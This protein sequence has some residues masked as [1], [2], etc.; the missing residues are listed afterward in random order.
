MEMKFRVRK[1]SQAF[2][3]L[4]ESTT[5][6]LMMMMTMVINGIKRGKRKKNGK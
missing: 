5:T 4:M 2:N 3:D 6:K 1:Y